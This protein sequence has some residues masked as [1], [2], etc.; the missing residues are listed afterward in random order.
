MKNKQELRDKLISGLP[1]DMTEEDQ[2]KIEKYIEYIINSLSPAYSYL[3]D[4][5][6]NQEKIK[7]VISII[8]TL[9]IRNKQ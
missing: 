7:D 2:K 3:E 8:E 5:N 6:S 4:I 9:K 1:L